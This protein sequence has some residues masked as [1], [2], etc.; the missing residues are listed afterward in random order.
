MNETDL[1][2]ATILSDFVGKEGEG[3]GGGGA[4]KFRQG[5]AVFKAQRLKW[6][7]R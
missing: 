5:I 2:L 6:M 7:S 4:A 1:L 3:G